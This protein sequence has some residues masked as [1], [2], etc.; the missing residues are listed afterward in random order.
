MYAIVNQL[1]HEAM[2]TP[3]L[4]EHLVLEN[5]NSNLLKSLFC[6]FFLID[7]IN[8]ELYLD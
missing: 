7:A 2:D 8:Y 1:I 5:L 6:K 4:L 3:A